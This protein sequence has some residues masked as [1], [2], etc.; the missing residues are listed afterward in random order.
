MDSAWC[1]QSYDISSFADNQPTVFIRWGMGTTDVSWRFCGWNIDDIEIVGDPGDSDRDGLSD[2]WEN[3]HFQTLDHG[4]LDDIE[5]DGLPNIYEQR[6][7]SDP[8]NPNT[9]GDMIGDGRE[10]FCGMDPTKFT[11]FVDANGDDSYDGLLHEWDGL[12]GPKR[13]IQAAID[14]AGR[15]CEVAVMPGLYRGLG[16][17]DLQIVSGGVSLIGLEGARETIIDCEGY[18]RGLYIGDVCDPMILVRGITFRNGSALDDGGAIYC[19]SSRLRLDSCVFDSNTSGKDGGA[20]SARMESEVE[21]RNCLFEGNVCVSRGG[22]VFSGYGMVS[23][24]NCSF[25]GNSASQGGAIAIAWSAANRIDDSVLWGNSAD[26]GDS[27][28]L[29]GETNPSTLQVYYCDIQG[30][31]SSASVPQGNVLEWGP[32]NI[33]E[34]PLFVAGPYG[35]CYLSQPLS[36]QAELSPCVDGGSVTSLNAG[37]YRCTTM[38]SGGRDL[39]T[40][41]LGYHYNRPTSVQ[42]V[43]SW[44]SGNELTICWKGTI[45]GSYVVQWSADM[46]NWNDVLVGETNCWTD[47]GG[48]S[49]TERYYRVMG[50]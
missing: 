46:E 26:T 3:A 39:G 10:H 5:P 48:A 35:D 31:E 47:A 15:N 50:N 4:P 18:S 12:H 40:V 41:D 29:L 2:R 19:R 16:N 28:A 32:G 45:T 24:S 8:T 20:L 9:D 27:I 49:K 6:V 1:L 23:L 37:L 14:L 30:G 17:R 34:D 21:I 36:G 33:D 42:I 7:D 13:S 22:G 25:A 43:S 38:T 11:Y 44:W